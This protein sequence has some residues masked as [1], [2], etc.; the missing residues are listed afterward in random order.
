MG[1]ESNKQ[2][3]VIIPVFNGERYLAEALASIWAQD[4]RPLEVIVIDDGSTDRT[5]EI[6]RS[7]PAVIYVYQPNQGHGA[8][9][10][11]GIVKATSDFVAFLDADDLWLPRKL[12]AQI[13]YLL[14]HPGTGYVIA[15]MDVLLESG[16]AWPVFLNRQHYLSNP[17]CFLPSALLTC[18]SVFKQIGGFDTSYRH[19]NDGDWFFRARDA[20]ISM[21]LLPEVLVRKRIHGDN[22]SYDKLIMLETMRVVRNSIKRKQSTVK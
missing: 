7:N 11:A 19:A 14:S 13:E 18:K 4:Y 17:P 16:V 9:K 5:A 3:S 21:G 20:G 2:V 22:L 8:A 12:T 10:N 1:R 6:A 15:H